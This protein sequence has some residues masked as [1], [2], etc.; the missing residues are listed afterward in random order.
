F[1]YEDYGLD[2]LARVLT[3]YEAGDRAALL[4]RVYQFYLIAAIEW[5]VER[6]TDTDVACAEASALMRELRVYDEQRRQELLTAGGI[7][8]GMDN[9]ELKTEADQLML[10]CELG[11][12]LAA[13]PS[14]FVGGSYSY[15]LMCWRDLDVYVLDP[16][17]DLKRCFEIGYE[18]TARLAAK[19]SRFT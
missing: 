13:Y 5:L 10:K 18:L 11:E 8:Y 17:H 3:A 16:A 15:D 2:F 9:T 4:G 19:K 14:W 6:W 7:G 1:I 12:L